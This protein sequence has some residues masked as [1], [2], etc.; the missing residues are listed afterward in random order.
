MHSIEDVKSYI[1]SQNKKQKKDSITCST[2]GK[3]L[4]NERYIRCMKCPNFFQCLNCLSVGLESDNHL[5]THNF[6]VVE[7]RPF[8]LY[9]EDWDAHD[10]ILLLFGIKSLGIGNWN[11]ISSFVKTKSALDCETHYVNVYINSYNAPLPQPEILPPIKLPPPPSYDTRPVESCPSVAHEKHMN[12]K[13]KKEKTTPAEY[14]GYMPYR[15]EF[16]IEWNNDAEAL[17]S[18]IEFKIEEETFQTFKDKVLLLMCYNDQLAERRF[19]TKVIE[20]WDIQNKEVKSAT[21]GEKDDPRILGGVTAAERAVDAKIISLAPYYGQPNMQQ[22][23]TCLHKQIGYFES[24]KKTQLWIENGVRSHAEGRIFSKFLKCVKNGKI[25]AADHEK[26][27]ELVT[28]LNKEKNKIVS[29]NDDLLSHPELKLCK[30]ENIHPQL[31]LA[32]KCL[33]MNEISYRGKFKKYIAL[34]IDPAH[35]KEM[36]K[37]YDLLE[38]LGQLG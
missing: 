15:H 17:V 35:E 20:D 10:E 30:V 7:P 5:Q 6:F 21:R 25:P 31:Y 23:T 28:E 11:E 4:L 2:C 32:L 29:Q 19:R 18:K 13:N 38:A 26:W 37:I 34:K 14:S 33:L 3:V 16:E 12:E 24:I 22:F 8:P 9:S 1:M 27:N 36:S